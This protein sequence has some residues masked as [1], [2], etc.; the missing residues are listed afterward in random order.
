MFDEYE[1]L[2]TKI[3]SNVIT[4]E[5]LSVLSSLMESLPVFILLTGSHELEKRK[6]EYWRTFLPKSDFRTISYLQR[7]DS[8]RLITQPVSGRVNYA[9]GI[10]DSIHRLTSGQPFYTQAICQRL[11]DYLNDH[12]DNVVTADVLDQVTRDIIENPLP[13]MI[14]MWDGF[15]EDEKIVLSLLGEVLSDSSGFAS[16]E[17]P[18]RRGVEVK[19]PGAYSRPSHGHGAGAAL[20]GR[21]PPEESRAPSRICLPDGPQS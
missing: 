20:Q 21:I 10:V 16:V 19:V 17:E 7:E 2:E 11:V 9:V 6:R 8:H 15:E 3:D 13:Q 1:L 12:E 18:L 4:E 5:V 14:F